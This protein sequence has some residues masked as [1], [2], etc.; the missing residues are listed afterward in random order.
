ML[1][2][3]VTVYLCSDFKKLAHVV[4]YPRVHFYNLL[5]SSDRQKIDSGRMQKS[6]ILENRD[7]IEFQP[8]L[9]SAYSLPIALTYF[10]HL[11]FIMTF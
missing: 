9:L 3:V 4:A 8:H 10:F 5:S 2:P 7:V 11:D 6:R 1:L